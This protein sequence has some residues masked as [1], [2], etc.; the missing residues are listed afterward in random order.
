MVFFRIGG[1]ELTQHQGDLVV[2]AEYVSTGQVTGTTYVRTGGKLMAHG[3]LAGGLIIDEGGEAIVHGQVSRNVIN[4][5]RLTLLGQVS[6]RILGHPPLNVTGPNQIVGTD[7][8][9]PFRGTS[10]S[11]T[12]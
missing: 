1:L 12:L 2:T 10:Y 6:G 4:H 11:F 3:Q 8:E 5:G 9:V 7:L